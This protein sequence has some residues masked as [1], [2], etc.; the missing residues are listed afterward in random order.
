VFVNPED[1]KGEKR[2]LRDAGGE[3]GVK[4]CTVAVSSEK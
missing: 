2:P 1:G 3:I 4:V